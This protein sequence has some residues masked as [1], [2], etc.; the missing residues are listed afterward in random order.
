MLIP[1]FLKSHV[2]ILASKRRNDEIKIR[3]IFR[4]VKSNKNYKP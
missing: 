4:S 2:A 1:K 3:S